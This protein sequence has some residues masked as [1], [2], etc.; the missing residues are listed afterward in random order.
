MRV[1]AADIRELIELARVSRGFHRPWIYLTDTRAVWR[2][3]LD[4]MRDGRFI[5][6]VVRRRDTR[7]LVG[8][9]NLS[10]I[11]RGT[12]QSAYLGFYAHARHA[13]RGFMAE[14]LRVLL[15]R[16][17]GAHRLH[18]V[19]ANIQPGND[20]SRRLVRRGGFRRE[21]FSPKYLKVGGRWR[22]HERWAIT[23]EMWR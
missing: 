2:R 10:E 3:H 23:R 13:G 17:F 20:P 1:A 11:V 18:R 6:Y 8:V 16:A 15:A 5:S 4:R 9:F 12:F 14:G 22:D 7:E 21:G 19:E